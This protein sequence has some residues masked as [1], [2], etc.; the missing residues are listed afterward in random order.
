MESLLAANAYSIQA[1]AAVATAAAAIAAV[2]GLFSANRHFRTVL[3][4]RLTS[5]YMILPNTLMSSDKEL[6]DY[7][8]LQINNRSAFPVN[9]NSLSLHMK[10]GWQTSYYLTPTQAFFSEGSRSLQPF[11]HHTIE[12]SPREKFLSLFDQLT[13]AERL[14]VRFFVTPSG[15][16]PVRVRLSGALRKAVWRGDRHGSLAATET[17][18]SRDYDKGVPQPAC[19]RFDEQMMFVELAD[20]RELGV[21][22]SWFPRLLNA[23]PE[24]RGA[25]R[26]SP[27]GLHWDEIDEDISVAGLIAGRGDMTRRPATAA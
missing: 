10:C 3:S 17:A 7:I 21:P 6:K 2:L 26:F 24:Q 8:Y 27:G 25:V 16:E 11:T 19:V 20:G 15:A 13:W 14:S 23:S 4:C 12:W 18:K 5:G 22:L 1:F 9:I